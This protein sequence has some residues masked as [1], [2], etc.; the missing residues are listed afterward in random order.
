M[1]HGHFLRTILGKNSLSR[2]VGRRNDAHRHA[3]MAGTVQGLSW[4]HV[5]KN[6]DTVAG[7]DGRRQRPIAWRRSQQALAITAALSRTFLVHEMK[8]II[9]NANC[10]L[11][12][13]DRRPQPHRAVAPATNPDPTGASAP[14]RRLE[15][16]RARLAGRIFS[17][18][19][20]IV[21]VDQELGLRP[22]PE[23]FRCSTNSST[24]TFPG[25]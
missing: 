10:Q 21:G 1:Q 6:S 11:I 23:G 19:G 20:N 12:L 3:C 5:P 17:S 18:P 25:A 14:H 2:G 9:T 4:R 15:W 22:F 13:N 16:M 7:A 24:P 8:F